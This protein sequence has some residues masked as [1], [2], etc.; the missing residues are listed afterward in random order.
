MKQNCGKIFKTILLVCLAINLNTAA[1]GQD[2]EAEDRIKR[3]P[4]IGFYAYPPR[5]LVDMPTA[6]TLPRA[7][8]D[9]AI[10]LYSQGGALG[11]VDIGLSSR[12][13]L[14]ISY[15]GEGIVSNTSP[16]WNPKIEFTLKLRVIDEIEYFPG[17][18]VGFTS[19]G[20][21]PWNDQLKRYA[22]KSRGFFAVASRSFYF[23]SWTA[24]WH[25]G[26][27]YSL[28]SDID[29]DGDINFFGGFDATFRYN[30]G[31]TGEYDLA[32]NDDKSSLPDGSTNYYGGKGRGYFNLSL[33]WLFHDNLELEAILK[34]L[35]VNRKAQLGES[36]TF[37]REVRITYIEPF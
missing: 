23:Y 20:F 30:L 21:G 24:G 7:S 8:Y 11:M 16:S 1:Y 4:A 13:Q 22:F 28:E 32:I 2:E 29:E 35:F 26:F 31:L 12:F 14:G 19:Q 15:G 18:T 17:V 36:I 9:I 37:T 6:G 10:R 33:R 5:W 34:D 3:P 25:A 27:N